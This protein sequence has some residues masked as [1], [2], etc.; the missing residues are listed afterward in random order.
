MQRG[1]LGMRSLDFIY[2]RRDPKPNQCAQAASYT[3]QGFEVGLHINTN[4]A[5]F[6]PTS[7]DTFYSQ[8]VS[9][10]TSSYPG[11][12]API[13]QRHHC[14]AWSDWLDRRK[15]GAEIRDAVGRQLLFLAAGLGA[16]PSRPLHGIGH[17]HALC[18]SGRNAHRRLQRAQPDD[19]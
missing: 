10:F 16:R 6:T 19:G 1:E 7:L 11:I 4:C 18:G 14:I 5:D 15:D 8:Q 9:D 13:T 2:L 3:A 12:P 17:A